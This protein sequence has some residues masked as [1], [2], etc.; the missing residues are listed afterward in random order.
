MEN[1]P[2]NPIE[3]DDAVCIEANGGVLIE[4]E[5]RPIRWLPLGLVATLTFLAGL[6]W[7]ATVLAIVGNLGIVSLIGGLLQLL[8]I[9]V[10]L[11]ALAL[12]V[13]AQWLSLRKP[14]IFFN[15]D[16]EV[17]ELVRAHSIRR[18]PYSV[19]TSVQVGSNLATNYAEYLLGSLLERLHIQRPGVA[20][21][22]KHGEVIRCATASGIEAQE[23]T[24]SV[25][26]RIQLNISRRRR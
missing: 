18:I 19:I 23:R 2:T 3:L 21:Q 6:L 25:G 4:P 9:S 11:F 14:V 13:Y 10:V 26:E 5:A 22:L 24:A 1:A 17:V 20:L 12:S 16:T 15:G 8:V 7:L